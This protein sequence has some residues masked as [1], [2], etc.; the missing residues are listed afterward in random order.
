MSQELK[1]L[2][3]SQK[4]LAF[5]WLNLPL[6][7]RELLK[8]KFAYISAISSKRYQRLQKIEVL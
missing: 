5:H 2:S 4:L 3:A 8:K 1:P 7:N 6:R